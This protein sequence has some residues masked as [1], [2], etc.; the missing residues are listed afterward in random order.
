[1]LK[2]AVSFLVI[3]L[4]MNFVIWWVMEHR[5]NDLEAD[6]GSRTERM[7]TFVAKI[8]SKVKPEDFQELVHNPGSRGSK[9][10]EIREILRD[11]KDTYGYRFVFTFYF[12]SGGKK[13]AYVVDSETD[14]S[15]YKK[16]PGTVLD[17][18]QTQAFQRLI[19]NPWY[20][21]HD[22]QVI[23][24]QNGL[25]R[26]ISGYSPIVVGTD[27]RSILGYVEV[28]ADDSYINKF[29]APII[30]EFFKVVLFSNVLLCVILVVHM[31]YIYY[32][33]TKVKKE[34]TL[35]M[36]LIRRFDIS[37][38]SPYEEMYKKKSKLKRLAEGVDHVDKS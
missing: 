25:V 32:R 28:V 27:K 21:T 7:A 20:A 14:S 11:C 34:C 3:L 33:M 13:V 22:R 17:V 37:N 36:D 23:L 38:V 16:P 18:P 24:Y 5:I 30:T 12:V 8:L 2:R 6:L 35:A 31:S 26:S 19:K 10:W 29:L 9:Y 15:A 1:M 4:G